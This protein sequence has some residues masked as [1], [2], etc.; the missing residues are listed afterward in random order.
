MTKERTIAPASD[1]GK[2][3][4]VSNRS[5][6]YSGVEAASANTATSTT[7]EP[8]CNPLTATSRAAQYPMGRIGRNSK[9]E[10]CPW[11]IS[12]G[13]LSVALPRTRARR[14]LIPNT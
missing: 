8:S 3:T 4:T 6:R 11:T 9:S 10:S 14:M 12:E 5:G 7:A 2:A 1:A 13:R